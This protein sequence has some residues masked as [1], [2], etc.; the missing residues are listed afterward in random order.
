MVTFNFIIKLLLLK[1][2]L[3]GISYN[4]ILIFIEVLIKYIYL[5]LYKES[6]I[7]EDLVYIFYKVI[8]I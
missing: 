1:E 7:V 2:S 4:S 5:E 3:T 8:I 6:S